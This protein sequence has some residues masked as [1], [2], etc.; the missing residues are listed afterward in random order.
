MPSTGCDLRP[1][2]AWQICSGPSDHNCHDHKYIPRLDTMAD[3]L[4]TYLALGDSMSIDLYTGVEGGGAVNQFHRWLNYHNWLGKSWALKDRTADMCRMRYV[5]AD[6]KGD[7][8]TLTIGGNDLLADKERYLD[9]GLLSFAQEHM[10]LLT[11]IRRQNPAALFIVGNIYAPQTPLPD[12]LV[13][14]LD[15]A[16]AVIASNVRSLDGRLADIRG[17]FR[18]HEAEYLC[19]DIEPSL[20]GA[21]VIAGLFQPSANRHLPPQI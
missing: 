6:A 14:A 16:N 5:P 7:V 12:G 20:K 15:E 17:A 1:P 21:T 2:L 19:Y 18:D 11:A 8:I 4:R 9:Q 10:G 3:D 13:K